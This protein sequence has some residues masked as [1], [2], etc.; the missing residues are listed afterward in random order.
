MLLWQVSIRPRILGCSNELDSDSLMLGLHLFRRLSS[1]RS[2]CDH[3][4]QEYSEKKYIFLSVYYSLNEFFADF[5]CI[6]LERRYHCWKCKRELWASTFNVWFITL[7]VPWSYTVSIDYDFKREEMAI[8]IFEIFQMEY[9]PNPPWVYTM[10]TCGNAL[11][12]TKT[13]HLLFQK[14]DISRVLQM[15]SKKG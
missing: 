1:F 4:S 12:V 7:Q 5:Y 8:N 14:V 3:H 11:A 2:H 6:S 10:S 15:R 9:A 13:S